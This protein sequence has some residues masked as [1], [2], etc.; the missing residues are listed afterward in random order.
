M[1]KFQQK[2][3]AIQNEEMNARRQQIEH[4]RQFERQ[5]VEADNHEQ[6]ERL[7]SRQRVA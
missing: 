6:R 3:L 1:E 5:A 2:M 4:M 7:A